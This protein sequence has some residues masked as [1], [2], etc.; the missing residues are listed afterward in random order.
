MR[1]A[2]AI[3]VTVRPRRCGLRLR[4][5]ARDSLLRLCRSPLVRPCLPSGLHNYSVAAEPAWGY[6][7]RRYDRY[8]YEQRNGY[9]SYSR[10]RAYASYGTS[11][12][13]RPS[14]TVRSEYRM[15]AIR[16]ESR[17][18]LYA[19]YQGGDHPTTRTGVSR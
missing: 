16:S 18:P 6:G 4:I 1:L 5:R 15:G 19:H 12:R 9:E 8:G 3:R 11:M 14:S 13:T 17:R 10:G 2:T 7:Q